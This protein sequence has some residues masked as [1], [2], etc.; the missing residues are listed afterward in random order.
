MIF[1][2]LKSVFKYSRRSKI[3]QS[4]LLAPAPNATLGGKKMEAG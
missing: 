3:R 1:K 4:K 2:D